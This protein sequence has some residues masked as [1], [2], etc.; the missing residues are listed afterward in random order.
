MEFFIKGVP[1]KIPEA[2]D[3]LYGHIRTQQGR[4]PKKTAKVYSDDL[5]LKIEKILCLRVKFFWKMVF[6]DVLFLQDYSRHEST[7]AGKCRPNS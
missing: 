4:L 7:E 1:H 6:V 3:H 2:V 5:L